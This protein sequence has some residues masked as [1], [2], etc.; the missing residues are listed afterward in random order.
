MK[1]LASLTIIPDELYVERGADEQLRSVIDDMGRPAYVLVARQ[2]GKTN[3]LL[4]A[5]RSYQTQEDIFV[6]LDVSN[7]LETVTEFFNSIVDAMID[8]GRVG[9]SVVS[10]IYD[11]RKNNLHLAAH[12]IHER[13]L[14]KVLESISGKIV[15]FLDEVDALGS[16]QYSDQVFAYIRSVYFAARTNFPIF[17]RLSYV[18]SGVAEPSELIKNKD[19]SPFNI[20]QKIYL[21]DFT[22]D[23][24][25][26][27]CVKAELEFD[28]DVKN[29]VY[30]WTG[31]NPRMSWDLLAQLQNSAVENNVLT[32]SSVDAAVRA[33]YLEK[34]DV[35]PVDH[36]RNLV[37][38]DGELQSALISMHFG[39]AA[40]VPSHV[41]N[42]L[43]LAGIAKLESSTGSLELRN[44]I[45]SESL[46]VSWLQELEGKHATPIERAYAAYRQSRWADALVLLE[47]CF[48][49]SEDDAKSMQ[50]AGDIGVCLFRTKAYDQAIAWLEKY[51]PKKHI[52]AALHYEMMHWLGLA[53][54]AVSNEVQSYQAF[55]ASSEPAAEGVNSYYYESLVNC[56]AH[57]SKDVGKYAGNIESI[58]GRILNSEGKFEETYKNDPGAANHVRCSAYWHLSTLRKRQGRIAD[59][60]HEL[61][62]AMAIGDKKYS[63]GIALE[64]ARLQDHGP[65]RWSVANEM[66]SAI[67]EQGYVI[68]ADEA[69]FP[70]A[71]TLSNA[72]DLLAILAIRPDESIFLRFRDYLFEI[73]SDAAEE[74]FVVISQAAGSAVTSGDVEGAAQLYRWAYEARSVGVDKKLR[75]INATN[76]ILLTSFEKSRDL[77]ESY[78]DEYLRSPDADL[79]IT[80]FRVV[81]SIFYGYLGL[82]DMRAGEII[83]LIKPLVKNFLQKS[84]GTQSH[85]SL[86]IGALI[87]DSCEVDWNYSIEK[88]VEASQLGIDWLQRARN[89]KKVSPPAYFSP[90]IV[91]SLV[92]RMRSIAYSKKTVPQ[93]VRKDKKI[94][95][96]ELVTVV[97]P[98]GVMK[99][100]KY[101]SFEADIKSGKL[102]LK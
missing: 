93:Y 17:N 76:S 41:V 68:E 35:P 75:R 36:I 3:L 89:L 81:Y 47:E 92:A 37:E 22:R 40:T 83:Q 7:P 26:R 85:E 72:G 33:L 27:F 59:A 12:R 4:H 32:A 94:G 65:T 16:R 78:L 101:K 23:E 51:T 102:I 97:L 69:L 1:K 11:F 14:R 25:F 53:H 48:T 87:I 6:Y 91:D 63:V 71:F 54:H 86:A 70:L 96:N 99:T 74:Y 19:I 61:A 21:D 67:I 49:T 44:R 98:D 24:F 39:K 77:S 95:R 13:E 100:G 45:I 80:D 15:I 56:C 60:L 38:K 66:A 8:T 30:A 10:E 55:S 46:S 90:D 42:K 84:V 18:L 20:G 57:Y 34:F 58:V 64:R 9:D 73:L 43:Y 88:Y 31:G 5:K 62:L 2:M 52:H 79:V 29:C 82:G 50:L 28:E